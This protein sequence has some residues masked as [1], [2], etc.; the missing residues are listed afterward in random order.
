MLMSD[1]EKRELCEFLAEAELKKGNLELAEELFKTRS[2][3]FIAGLIIHL[4][5]F[6]A[7]EYK[8]ISAD[9]QKDKTA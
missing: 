5:M 6:L 2:R 8:H 9:G 7:G 4:T 3:L 1:E